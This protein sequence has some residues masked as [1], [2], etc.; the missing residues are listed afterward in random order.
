MGWLKP[1]EG[2]DSPPPHSIT[3]QSPACTTP[4]ADAVTPGLG[5]RGGGGGVIT[6]NWPGP[7]S[8][9]RNRTPPPP[10]PPPTLPFHASIA[11]QLR[12]RPCPP[13]VPPSRV[14]CS[15]WR[16][17]C[18]ALSST[19]NP[20]TSGGW[21]TTGGLAFEGSGRGLK[22]QV[23]ARHF[24]PAA[25][26]CPPPLRSQSTSSLSDRPA[27]TWQ[28]AQQSLSLPPVAGVRAVPLV[29]RAPRGRSSVRGAPGEWAWAVAYIPMP[30]ALCPAG[31]RSYL[32]LAGPAWHGPTLQPGAGRGWGGGRVRPTALASATGH[33]CVDRPWVSPANMHQ[34]T[35]RNHSLHSRI[36]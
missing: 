11:H 19:N 31:G 22:G 14:L 16:I 15:S 25:P 35:Q 27:S 23:W 1:P 4:W 28:C 8:H 34:K 6:V 29:P 10:A 13:L 17:S 24:A 20:H 32:L 21:C 9:I 30:H 7:G 33:G 12:Q 2:L 3:Q 5:M 36:H 18:S 26:A